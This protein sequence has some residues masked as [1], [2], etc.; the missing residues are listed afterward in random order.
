ML[1]YKIKCE[2]DLIDTEYVDAK[3]LIDVS[4]TSVNFSEGFNFNMEIFKDMEAKEVA[5]CPCHQ[6]EL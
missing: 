5:K 2:I 3:V 4:S 6:W 1:S